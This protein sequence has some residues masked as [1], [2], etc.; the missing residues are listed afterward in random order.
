[1]GEILTLAQWDDLRIH[2]KRKH[3]NLKDDD[4]PYYEAEEQDMMCM[5]E[6]KLQEY[7]ENRLQTN[8]NIGVYSRAKEVN[9]ANRI[10]ESYPKLME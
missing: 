1:M 2:L 6:Y 7:Q 9:D 5:I 8:H 3:P 4:L 10:I